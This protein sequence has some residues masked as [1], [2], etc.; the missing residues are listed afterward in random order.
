M[1]VPVSMATLMVLSPCFSLLSSAAAVYRN[2]SDDALSTTSERLKK[3]QYQGRLA[4]CGLCRP[5]VIEGPPP[6]GETEESRRLHDET[7]Y[8]NFNNWLRTF[9]GEGVFSHSSR[10]TMLDSESRPFALRSDRL[11]GVRA[12]WM[13]SM[14]R[15]PEHGGPHVWTTTFQ[16]TREGFDRL[17]LWWRRTHWMAPSR[18]IVIWHLETVREV[19]AIVIRY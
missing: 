3:G 9:E 8:V 11:G 17:E 7:T 1:R 16:G 19:N 12:D 18:I 2:A 13:H 4:F 5:I 6:A 15:D 14:H 10:S